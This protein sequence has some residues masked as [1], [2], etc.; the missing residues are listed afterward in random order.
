MTLPTFNSPDQETV[1]NSVTDPKTTSSFAVKANDVLVAVGAV[2]GY[3]S[4]LNG[5]QGGLVVTDGTLTW[6]PR[7][8]V[9][10]TDFTQVALI[11]A[12]VDTDKTLAATFDM[13]GQ[14]GVNAAYYG[15]NVL[16]FRSSAGVG[17]ST[18]E[19]GTDATGSPPAAEPSVTLTTLRDHSA[20][21]VVVSDWT[22]KTGARTWIDGDAGAVVELTDFLDS[23]H[24]RAWVGYYPNAGNAGPKV[25]GMTAPVAMKYSIAAIEIFGTPGNGSPTNIPMLGILQR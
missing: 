2:E 1:W 23:A 18:K 4:G 15:G 8:L 25:V 24:Y 5:W 9:Q 13:V 11:T 16:T 19:N 21:V 10:V 3:N 7:Q 12:P 20:I 6:T 17:N 22:A 14:V